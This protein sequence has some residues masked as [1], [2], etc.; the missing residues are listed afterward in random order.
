MLLVHKNVK[1]VQID[2]IREFKTL[3]KFL[4][5]LGINYRWACLHSSAQN[6]IVECL[7][8]R[9]INVGLN[10]FFNSIVPLEY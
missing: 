1:H 2:G 9:I 8:R 7:H 5:N 6:G 4:T 10:L 3:A